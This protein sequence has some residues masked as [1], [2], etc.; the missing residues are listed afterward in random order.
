MLIA[1]LHAD[2]WNHICAGL[3]YDLVAGQVAEVQLRALELVG[4]LPELHVERLMAEGA[5][6]GR[7]L[8]F[9]AQVHPNHDLSGSGVSGHAHVWHDPLCSLP[10]CRS[11]DQPPAG[12]RAWGRAH[13]PL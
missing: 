2:D 13:K 12:L 5:L 8:E 3:S 9:V 11:R 7:L 1:N 10:C 6:E 4:I